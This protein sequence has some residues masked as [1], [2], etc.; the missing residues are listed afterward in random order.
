MFLG[1]LADVLMWR[2]FGEPDPPFLT[3]TVHTHAIVPNSFV[4]VTAVN[5]ERQKE[6][7]DHNIQYI[8]MVDT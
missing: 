3:R 6:T 5:D 4:S 8:C 2:G 1:S 7:G